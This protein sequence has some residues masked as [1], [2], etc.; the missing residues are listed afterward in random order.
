MKG[1]KILVLVGIFCV[2]IQLGNAAQ[3]EYHDHD[4][5]PDYGKYDEYSDYGKHDDSPYGYEHKKYGG[6]PYYPGGEYDHL[7][8]H[9]YEETRECCG[10]KSSLYKPVVC[11]PKCT[12]WYKYNVGEIKY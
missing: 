1:L 10:C 5:Y 6:V 2:V 7:L 11:E 12:P 9:C 8:G 4:E 3:T